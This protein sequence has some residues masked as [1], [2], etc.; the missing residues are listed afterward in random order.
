[1]AAAVLFRIQV[2]RHVVLCV[3]ISLHETLTRDKNRPPK[4]RLAITELHSV[5]SQKTSFSFFNQN[6]SI[7]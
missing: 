2:F 6:E 5:L 4:R 1:M 3:L 7:L